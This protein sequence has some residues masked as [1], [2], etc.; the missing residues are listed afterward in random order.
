MKSASGNSWK[1]WAS[2]REQRHRRK[3]C[4]AHKFHRG[5]L[6]RSSRRHQCGPSPN[7]YSV[8][9]RNKPRRSWYC[10]NPQ[11]PRRLKSGASSF[12]HLFRL[13]LT[14]RVRGLNKR[15]L[16]QGQ[17]WPSREQMISRASAHRPT[18]FG[19]K[20]CVPRTRRAQRLFCGKF[21]DRHAVF[22]RRISFSKRSDGLIEIHA[23][24]VVSCF[25][26]HSLPLGETHAQAAGRAQWGVRRMREDPFNERRA[27]LR[28]LELPFLF[29]SLIPSPPAWRNWQTRWTQNPVLARVCG[30]D[31]LRRHT[32]T[33]HFTSEN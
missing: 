23:A 12:R 6:R 13:R 14:S 16:L 33:M 11:K 2:R 15:K 19:N 8:P 10:S 5:H 29:C 31:P 9:G 7:R 22:N 28:A 20:L 24:T 21:L 27:D 25:L 32:S 30:F 26:Y 17:R 1:R 4:R 3:H 18:P